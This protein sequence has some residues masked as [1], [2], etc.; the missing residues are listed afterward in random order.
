VGGCG[1]EGGAGDK[2]TERDE[3]EEETNARQGGWAPIRTKAE[4]RRG[5]DEDK[6]REE[7]TQRGKER[8]SAM[9]CGGKETKYSHAPGP[10]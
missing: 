6:A 9:E 1:R 2:N 4:R 5:G 7:Q 3:E 10:G 8:K